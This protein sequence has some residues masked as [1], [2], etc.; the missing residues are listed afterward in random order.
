MAA[1]ALWK[2]AISFG[3]VYIPVE[4]YT[5]VQEHDL[6]LTMLDKRD[7]SPVGYKRYNKN[8]GKEVSWGDIVKGYEYE[9]NE[10][11]VLSDED[12]KRANVEATQTIDIM[13]FVDAADVPLTYYE[14]PYYLAPSRGG[15]KVYALLRETLRKSGKIGIATVVMRTKQHL[16]ALV[17]VED[18]IVLNTLRYA[19]EIRDA[20]ELKL[21]PATLKA[22]GI[23]D[24]E[25]QM[26]L[27]LVDGM[28]EDWKPEQYHDT[29]KED[30]L[31]L[32]KKKIKAGQTKTITAAAPEERAPKASNVVDLVALLQDSLGKRKG[33]AKPRAAEQ[34]DEEEE[35]E[36]K[37]RARNGAR[38]G[39]GKASATHRAASSSKAGAHATARKKPAASRAKAA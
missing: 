6:D 5:A 25:L 9:D 1:R 2:G 36:A 21:P 13:A 18:K 31:A 33:G 34:E 39:S 3:L 28:S 22:A 15:A 19:T 14:T 38:S 29:Y 37:P 17:C 26:A 12:L 32:V 23:S 11:V 16:C 4:M 8:T 35:E 24:K 10:Y 20:E 7:F 30:V 27:S